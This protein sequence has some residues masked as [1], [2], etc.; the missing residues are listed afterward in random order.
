MKCNKAACPSVIIAE[1][2][3]AAG[4]E[5]VVLLKDLTEA[6]FSNGV[7]PKDLD[8]SYILNL[9]KGKG[10]A[11]N[12][13]NHSGLK[14]ADQAMKLQERAMV[15]IDSMLCGFVQG[16]GSSDAIYIISQLT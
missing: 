13:G 10:Y 9:Y 7:I 11:L 2:L 4:E 14:F 3:R 1:M 6:L 15:N 8:E 5:S 16:Q 12:R